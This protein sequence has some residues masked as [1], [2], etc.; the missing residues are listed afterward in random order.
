MRVDKLLAHV[1]YG[2]RKDVKQLLKKGLFT[3][4]GEV[5]KSAKAHVDPET[6]D[7]AF[8]GEPILYREHLY[9]MMHKPA[10]VLSATEDVSERTVVDLL[11][12]ED[13]LF[14]PFPVGRLD[15]D[16]TGLLLLTNDGKWAHG[17]TSP[18]RKIPKTYEVLTAEPVTD[19][20]ADQLQQGVTLDDGYETRPAGVAFPDESR[21]RLYL[22]IDEG[23]YHQV[24]RMLAAVGNHVDGLKR[25]RIGGLPLDES[26]EAGTY[27]ELTEKEIEAFQNGQ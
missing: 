23:K 18:A 15:K 21:S 19:E 3:V 27:R 24:K 17:I 2:S 8:G 6:D 16:T 25:I 12:E 5:V 13:R 10:G 22:T 1:G 9:V 26:L 7:L 11:E 20:M 4:N 14:Q